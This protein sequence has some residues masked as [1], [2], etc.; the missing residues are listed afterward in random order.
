LNSVCVYCGS[1]AGARPQY[2]AAARQVGQTLA[3]RGLELVYG[4]ARV[5]LM[6][7]MAD[8][9]L[10]AGGRVY[11]VLPKALLRVEIAHPGLTE[12][13]VTETLH[14]RKAL[15]SA[16][17]DAFVALPGGYGT[18]DELF[19]ALTWTQVGVHRKPCGILNIEGFF[20][21]L[22]AYLDHATREELIRPVLRPLLLADTDFDRLLDRMHGFELP[23]A[24]K[25]LTGD[26][27]P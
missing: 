3:R 9:A 26:V 7:A 12:L 2:L 15:M 6:G 17:A 25:A 8:A 5:G 4:G 14:E 1:A 22:L 11:G 10:E 19:E 13:R 27:K 23:D 16:R 18:L 24:V 21:N 20:D